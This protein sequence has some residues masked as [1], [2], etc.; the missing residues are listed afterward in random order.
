MIVLEL[1][2]YGI[3]LLIIYLFYK[4]FKNEIGDQFDEFLKEWPLPNWLNYVIG[5]PLFP[6]LILLQ[7]D[8]YFESFIIWLISIFII[9]FLF[10]SIKKTNVF[11]VF[12]ALTLFLTLTFGIV[13]F[14]SLNN[15]RDIICDTLI[16]NYE[17]EY[18]TE[19]YI[20]SNGDG[21]E[22]EIPIINS[23]NES[24]DFILVQIF[25]VVYH[26]FIALLLLWNLKIN[27]SIRRKFN[28]IQESHEDSKI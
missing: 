13:I 12:Q 14:F 4:K 20:D 21:H 28:I 27:I 19:Y 25:P 9:P 10:F 7:L 16:N 17:V 23:G 3:S 15:S 24:L 5:I 6:I 11:N 26:S 1:L 2:I 8:F 22:R 18:T